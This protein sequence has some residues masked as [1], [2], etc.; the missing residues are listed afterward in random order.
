[1]NR[2]IAS[3]Q[4]I[5]NDAIHSRNMRPASHQQAGTRET[6]AYE[7][8]ATPGRTPPVT[9]MIASVSDAATVGKEKARDIATLGSKLEVTTRPR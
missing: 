4:A 7:R 5:E 9:G 6:W 3:A 2:C 1:M 8:R